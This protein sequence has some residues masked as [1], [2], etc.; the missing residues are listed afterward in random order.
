MRQRFA[1]DFI[2]FW[3]ISYLC[4]VCASLSLL[5]PPFPLSSSWA[6]TLPSHPLLMPPEHSLH[7]LLNHVEN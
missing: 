3:T 6:Q 5:L 1:V 2:M 4:P 7:K